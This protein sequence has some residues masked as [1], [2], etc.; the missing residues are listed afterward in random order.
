MMYVVFSSGSEVTWHTGETF[1]KFDANKVSEIQADCD[2]L[3]AVERMF[4]FFVP[5][6][7]R[8]CR[9][10]GDFARM[11]AANIIPTN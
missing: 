5:Q 6:G 10:V 1:P 2:E 7:K 4:P 11:I 3:D 8:V 9:F